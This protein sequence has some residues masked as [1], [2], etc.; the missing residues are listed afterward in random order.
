MLIDNSEVYDYW[1]RRNWNALP[2]LLL[3]LIKAILKISGI[4]FFNVF[5]VNFWRWSSSIETL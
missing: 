5:E 3:L 4:F 2:R 1:I